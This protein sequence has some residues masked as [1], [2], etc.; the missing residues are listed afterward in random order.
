MTIPH[1]PH[2]SI[3]WTRIFD[4]FKVIILLGVIEISVNILPSKADYFL[5]FPQQL[6]APLR[7][8]EGKEFHDNNYVSY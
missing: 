5:D 2:E 3:S 6:I 1:L 7:E 8:L 4:L